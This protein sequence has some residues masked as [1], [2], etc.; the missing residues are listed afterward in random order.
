[1]AKYEVD[2]ARS[3]RGNITV[4]FQGSEEELRE[5]LIDN[6]EAFPALR[7]DFEMDI[8][9]LRGDYYVEVYL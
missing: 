1:M 6:P 4:D 7:S 5:Y 2:W 9:P 8:T 3:D